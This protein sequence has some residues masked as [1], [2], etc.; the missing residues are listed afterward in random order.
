MRPAEWSGKAT[1]E[2]Q[3]DIFLT[4]QVF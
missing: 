4:L 2:N 1:V 3:Q